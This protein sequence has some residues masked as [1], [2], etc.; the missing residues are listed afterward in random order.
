MS[1]KALTSVKGRLTYYT[2][3]GEKAGLTLFEDIF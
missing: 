3:D 2:W 1:K